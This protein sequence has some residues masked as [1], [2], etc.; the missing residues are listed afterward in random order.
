MHRHRLPLGGDPRIEA[1]VDPVD[2]GLA[3]GQGQRGTRRKPPGQR[4]RDA[5]P[6]PRV[7]ELVHQAHGVG[8]LGVDRLAGEDQLLRDS[9]RHQPRQPLGTPGP[10]QDAELHL[11]QAEL[12]A[13]LG[14]PQIAGERELQAAAESEPVDGGHRRLFELLEPAE[15][16][17]QPSHEGA[18]LVG[19]PERLDLTEVGS[20]REAPARPGDHQRP[21]RRIAAQRVQCGPD[22]RSAVAVPMALSRSGRLS[23]STATRSA[24]STFS[25]SATGSPF[26]AS[27]GRR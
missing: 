24:T 21:H 9:R 13:A 14:D 7:R 4:Q 10:R 17:G 23:V 3:R 11:R 8:A 1:A 22:Q 2:Q 27:S 6:L 25:S 26:R 19:G 5:Q 15:H 12:G 20:G 16:L 18:E